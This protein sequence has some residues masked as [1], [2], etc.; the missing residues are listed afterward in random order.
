MGRSKA[1][2]SLRLSAGARLMVMRLRLQVVA[3]VLEGGPDTLFALPDGGV[4]QPHGDEGREAGA[5]V[6]LDLDGIG[7]DPVER[8]ARDP[9]QHGAR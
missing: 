5:D 8:G 3:A 4:G 2:P 1:E 9:V 7:L 6:D